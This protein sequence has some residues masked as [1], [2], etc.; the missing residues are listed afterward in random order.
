MHLAITHYF[1]YKYL[2][3]YLFHTIVNT[4]ILFKTAY[5]GEEGMTTYFCIHGEP[6]GQR[7]LLGYSPRGCKKLNTT[8]ETQHAYTH[9]QVNEN[10]SVSCSVLSNALQPYG[11]QPT[12]LLCPCNCPGMNTGVDNPPLFQT[13]VNFIFII[14]ISR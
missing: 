5:V 6:H 11:L 13:Q 7:S 12:W 4:F 3:S 2:F 9:T 1:H 14:F 8:E 10:E